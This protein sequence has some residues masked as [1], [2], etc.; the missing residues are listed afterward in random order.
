[1]NDDILINVENVSKKFCRGLKQSL[2]YGMN[3]IFSELNPFKK[4]NLTIPFHLIGN[5][6]SNTDYKQ[7]DDLRNDEFWA[8][9]NISF[10]VRRGEMLGLIGQNGAG[11]STL[12]KVLN[13]IFNPTGGR[14][15]MKGRVQSLIELGAGF[16]SIL[17]GKE[18]VY[19]NAAVL[20]I[21]KKII[22]QAL[23]RI[24]EFAGIEEFMDTPVLKYSSGMKA[25]LG[26]A[27]ITQLDPDVLL[28]DEVLAVGD[29]AFQEK[30]MRRMD[31]L[32]QSNIAIIFVTHSLYQV[33]ALCDTALWLEKG[34]VV[35]Y[36]NA[37][38]VVRSYLDNQEQ[39]AMRE[40]QS[41]GVRYQGR[42]TEATKAYFHTRDEQKSEATM[43]APSNL[44]E[45]I[46][47][48]LVELVDTSG[49]KR[50]EF[51]FL[52]DLTVK[53]HYNAVRR[54]YRPLFNL[55]FFYKKHSIFETSMLIDGHGPDWVEGL[56]SVECYIP[57]LPL[58]P[59]TYSISLFVRS[60][61][62]IADITTMRSVAQFRITDE[63]LN[64]IP[65]RGPMALNHLRQGSPVYLPRIWRFYNGNELVFT[66]KSNY[67]EPT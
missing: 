20:G 18:N 8:L 61:E 62:G 17:S 7:N 35:Q 56:G 12:L 50:T 36:G 31:A 63:R 11:K 4:N 1:M 64:Q 29:V 42:V 39:Q 23:P 57:H 54:L 5:S 58:T 30:C 66:L 2:W 65:M 67:K 19:I 55:R 14:V 40:A 41:E 46:E 59:G 49:K 32:R 15:T 43:K 21:P 22:D 48:T 27:V 6:S 24:I 34:R 45:L 25:R 38:D 60:G 51:P 10:K 16:N 26:F 13:G 37:A 28:I 3:D 47:I 52:S 44:K 53:I 9:K 33:E